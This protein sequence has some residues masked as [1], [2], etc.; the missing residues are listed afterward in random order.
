MTAIRKAV[1]DRE[2]PL[3]ARLLTLAPRARDSRRAAGNPKD[4]LRTKNKGREHY[5][6]PD[7]PIATLS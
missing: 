3:L 6:E 7:D 4:K 2:L 5:Y 1:S